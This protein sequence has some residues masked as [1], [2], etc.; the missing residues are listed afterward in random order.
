MNNYEHEHGTPP[1][2]TLANPPAPR[3]RRR[4]ALS[5]VQC[6]RRKIKC[7]RLFPCSHCL[8]SKDSAN[9]CTYVELPGRR[10][11]ASAE[12]GAEMLNDQTSISVPSNAQAKGPPHE[13]RPPHSVDGSQ[14]SSNIN[15]LV[16]RVQQ[17]EKIVSD[18]NTDAG[19][20]GTFRDFRFLDPK[21]MNVT[22]SIQKSRFFGGS[23][24]MN[25]LKEFGTLNAFKEFHAT[26]KNSELSYLIQ[27]CKTMARAAKAEHPTQP[28]STLD[29]RQLVPPRGVADILVSLYLRTFETIHRILHV[30]TFEAELC[31]YWEDPQASPDV[32]VIK[33]L[34][35]MAIGTCFWQD[36]G[37]DLSSRFLVPQWIYASQSWINLP[38]EKSRMNLAGLQV[39]CLLVL[40]RQSSPRGGDVVWISEGFLLRSAMMMG[41]HRDPSH[42]PKINILQAE[43]RRRLWAFV[44]EVA[45]IS[46]LDSGMPP[47]ISHEDFDCEPPSN[48]S[49]SE[50]DE[51]TSVRP[52]SSSDFTPTSISILLTKSWR[53][54]LETVKLLNCF[55][56]ALTYESVI[57]LGNALTSVCKDN[58]VFL[59]NAAQSPTPPTHFQQRLLDLYHR[60]FLLVLHHPFARR[61]AKNPHFYFSRKVCLDN[62]LIILSYS[63]HT[64]A[65]PDD[66]TRLELNAGGFFKEV[67]LYAG[68][69]VS[70]ELIDQIAE[71]TAPLPI[72]TLS[73]APLH[74]AIE[75]TVELS[76]QRILLGETNVKGN[77][78]LSA[79][80]A[81]IRGLES[82]LSGEEMEESMLEAAMTS[83]KKC[84]ALLRSMVSS[85]PVGIDE[86]PVMEGWQDGFEWD[87]MMQDTAFEAFEVPDSWMFSGWED[88]NAW[89]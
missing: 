42:F 84:Y 86:E 38:F 76:T 78:F 57:R 17:L 51:N 59:Q 19:P 39:Q 63:D 89:S 24:W 74:K 73:R 55:R 47:L 46:S 25:L 8:Q 68:T 88:N 67:I 9:S 85:T 79:V 21:N 50:M 45:V 31:R 22:G 23:H 48:I 32:F 37:I 20:S 35:V 54:R 44:L 36:E 12:A 61:A 13:A 27:K 6:R 14:S 33:L 87:L 72:A 28:S 11:N 26:Q 64:A 15:E 7:D 62:A 77:V 70:L 75:D 60:R 58:N 80:L 30:P 3:K 53:T 10:R 83:A 29:Y 2:L 4:P 52:V 81:Q 40:A 1:T 66:Y 34:L 49:D 65:I 82:G 41:L 16:D 69:L 5:C 43:L 18:P 56:S 71:E